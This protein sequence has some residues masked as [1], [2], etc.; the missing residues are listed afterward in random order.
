MLQPRPRRTGS[1]HLELLVLCCF[2]ALMVFTPALA[3]SWSSS[4]SR[5]SSLARKFPEFAKQ[6]SQINALAVVVDV[7]EFEVENNR[8]TWIYTDDCRGLAQKLE[9]ALTAALGAKGYPVKAQPVLSVGQGADTSKCRVFSSWDKRD[10]RPGDLAPTA[11]PFYVDSTLNASAAAV[12]A[13]R[14]VA[15]AT[16]NAKGPKRGVPE[17]IPGTD[18]VREALGADYAFV[19]IGLG[20]HN[21]RYQGVPTGGRFGGMTGQADP[22]PYPG[23]RIQIAVIDCRTGNVLW[24]DGTSDWRAFSGKRM[25]GIA[26]GFVEQMP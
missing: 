26:K 22:S 6:K 16:L 24:A 17:V 11:P 18:T 3:G 4:W 12:S 19:A 7:A 9:D 8:A 5:E 25:E 14:G 23:S 10:L 13:W 2:T 21:V 1:S 20:T 15:Q